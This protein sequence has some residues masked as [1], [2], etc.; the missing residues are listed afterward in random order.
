MQSLPDFIEPELA[1]LVA[2]APEADEWVQENK[3]DGSR[4]AARIEGRRGPDADAARPRLDCALPDDRESFS[5]KG[6]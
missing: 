1:V 2:R 6:L 5:V 3:L 4:T